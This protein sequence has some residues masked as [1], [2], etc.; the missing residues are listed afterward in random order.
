MY[1]TT[2]SSWWG[3]HRSLADYP[4]KQSVDGIL[5]FT[6]DA[7]TVILY[8]YLVYSVREIEESGHLLR[9]IYGFPLIFLAYLG[10]GLLRRREYDER[11][12]VPRLLLLWGVLSAIAAGSYNLLYWGYPAHMDVWN[13]LFIGIPLIVVAGFRLHRARYYSSLGEAQT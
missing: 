13:W 11:A 8:V 2:V 3:Y 5:R 10:S 1:F 6:F 7:L 9:Y 12:S 4:Y